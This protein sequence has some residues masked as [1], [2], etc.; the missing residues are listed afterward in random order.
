MISAYQQLSKIQVAAIEEKCGSKAK[1]MI[2]QLKEAN[3]IYEGNDDT[4]FHGK[5]VMLSAKQ[6]KAIIAQMGSKGV[7]LLYDLKSVGL[8][9]AD[10]DY[11]H[12]P[13]FSHRFHFK[14]L[15]SVDDLDIKIETMN[16]K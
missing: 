15:G 13:S 9:Y 14:E 16:I 8:G 7:D 2:D 6:S 11:D 12:P 5:S 10:D 1:E 3:L 4:L